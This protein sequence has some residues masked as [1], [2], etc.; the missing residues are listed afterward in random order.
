M[1]LGKS[2]WFS[3][4][5][6]ILIGG[7]LGG[8]D[9]GNQSGNESQ[10]TEAGGE[11]EHFPRMARGEINSVRAETGKLALKPASSERSENT[12]EQGEGAI[13]FK[14]AK[15][16]KIT[17]LGEEAQLADLKAGQQAEIAYS[18]KEGETNKAGSVEVTEQPPVAK[19]ATGE[20]KTV[21]PDRR[22]IILGQGEEM[23]S[24][25]V[26]QN[27]T[28]TLNG[29][30]G[31]LADLKAGQQAE[32]EYYVQNESNRASSVKIGATAAVSGP[33]PG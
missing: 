19:T 29:Q 7:L 31:E 18:V 2:R 20:I 33:T 27:A 10:D 4:L 13:Q 11:K 32:I 5:A 25:K 3:L 8:C 24:F 15:D 9:G 22:K 21:K 16:A 17:V 12:T 1:Y 6:L 23:V 30:D 14:L 28:I 26:A